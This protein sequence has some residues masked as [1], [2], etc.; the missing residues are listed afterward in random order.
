MIT[1]GHSCQGPAYV[2]VLLVKDIIMHVRR[3]DWGVRVLEEEESFVS[4]I[5]WRREGKR[6]FKGL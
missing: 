3:I 4:R 2:V 5:L 6:C 1:T